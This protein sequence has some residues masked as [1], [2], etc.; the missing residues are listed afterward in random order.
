MLVNYPSS[1]SLYVNGYSSNTLSQKEIRGNDHG[2]E[3]EEFPMS[4]L[5]EA[6]GPGYNWEFEKCQT[7]N[8]KGNDKSWPSCEEALLYL[9]LLKEAIYM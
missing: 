7:E 4:H 5:D 1:N 9:I 8:S 3:E 2:E 6:R